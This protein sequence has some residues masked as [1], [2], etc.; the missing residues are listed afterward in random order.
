[1]SV[2]LDHGVPRTNIISGS[3]Y[4]GVSREINIW[5]RLCSQVWVS[6]IE[7]PEA[8]IKQKIQERR[9]P[10]SFFLHYCW[11]WDIWTIA[12]FWSTTYSLTFLGSEVF[13]L[14]LSLF[15]S[16]PGPH[17]SQECLASPSHVFYFCIAGEPWLLQHS[18]LVPHPRKD[19]MYFIFYHWHDNV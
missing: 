19:G 18:Y 5:N 13:R 6:T 3:I 2:W 9:I 11:S 10:L 16:F 17:R 14:T 7:S 15:H 4:E 8:W 1:M 12:C